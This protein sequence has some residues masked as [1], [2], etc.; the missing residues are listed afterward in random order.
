MS[1]RPILFQADII[2]PSVHAGTCYGYRRV[3]V[4]HT[5]QTMCSVGPV[6]HVEVEREVSEDHGVKR[7]LW[8]EEYSVG[9]RLGLPDIGIVM[10]SSKRVMGKSRSPLRPSLNEADD[11]QCLCHP[12]TPKQG[13]PRGSISQLKPEPQLFPRAVTDGTEFH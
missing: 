4:L 9:S 13:Q 3:G 6:V 2:R 7:T 12:W 5:D 8:D 10:G 11:I 1:S